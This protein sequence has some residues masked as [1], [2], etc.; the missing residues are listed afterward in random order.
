MGRGREIAQ[1][2]RV[3]V[4]HYIGAGRYVNLSLAWS[5]GV[6]GRTRRRHHA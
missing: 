3:C 1:K 6:A 4:V 2:L 5:P